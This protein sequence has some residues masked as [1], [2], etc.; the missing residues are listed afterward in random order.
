M[1]VVLFVLV[2]GHVQAQLVLEWLLVRMGILHFQDQHHAHHVLL[3]IPAQLPLPS[4]HVRQVGLRRKVMVNVWNVMLDMLVQILPQHC[5]QHHQSVQQEHTLWLDNLNVLHVQLELHVQVQMMIRINQIVLKERI[6]WL[7]KQHVRIVPVECGVRL[8]LHPHS[9]AHLVLILLMVM[10]FATLVPPGVSV[11]LIHNKIVPHNV[12]G[13]H[14]V[15]EMLRIAQHALQVF[16]ALQDR[17]KQLLGHLVYLLDHTTTQPMQF[18]TAHHPQHHYVPLVD[19]DLLVEVEQLE[20]DVTLHVLLDSTAHQDQPTLPTH[21]TSVPLDTIVHHL[22][23]MTC[24]FHVH[25]EH[26][27]HPLAVVL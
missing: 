18:L 23:N 17:Q 7:V 8:P 4:H 21:P 5:P 11:V 15:V 26:T 2:V 1:G 12:I 9:H 25:Q 13:A 16:S 6:R 22:Q 10:R 27:I 19:L 24:N 14:G 3:D 20:K